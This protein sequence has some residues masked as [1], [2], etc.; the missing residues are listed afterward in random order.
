MSSKDIKTYL[1]KIGRKGGQKSRRKLDPKTAQ[2][3]GLLRSARLAYRKYHAKCFWSYD[4]NLN[5]TIN[6]V[7]WVGQQL[8]KHGGMSLAP[9]GKKLCR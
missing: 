3:M 4:P 6:D 7:A 2:L 8:L 5:I 9:L 1:A